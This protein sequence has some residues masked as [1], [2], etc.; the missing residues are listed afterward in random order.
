MREFVRRYLKKI[1]IKYGSGIFE[2]P[3]R[4]KA[5]LNDLCPDC[6]KETFLL[7]T[8]LAK[9]LVDDLV[10]LSGE[11]AYQLKAEKLKQRLINECGIDDQSAEWAVDSWAYALGIINENDGKSLY[12]LGEKYFAAEDYKKA[13]I[14]FKKAADLGSIK[15][16]KAL[17]DMYQN[18]WKEKLNYKESPDWYRKAA[19]TWYKK[20]AKQGDIDAQTIL[21]SIYKRGWGV[22]QDFKQAVSWYQKAAQAG[23]EF[24][25]YNLGY[26]YQ[27]GL[28]VKQSFAQAL[29]WYLKSMRQ[30]N[31]FAQRAIKELKEEK[32]PNN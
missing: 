25:Q 5:L 28:G 12:Q 24:A 23:H 11:E 9:K 27:N 19:I 8:V 22:R 21:G 29:K 30:G 32:I 6:Q 31:D 13:V 20:A 17:G 10:E 3:K 16:Q 15:G 18:G 7:T 4:L 1:I 14:Y 2:Q 26:L